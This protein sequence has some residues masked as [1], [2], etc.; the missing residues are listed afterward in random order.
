MGKD[1]PTVECKILPRNP[2]SIEMFQGHLG[3]QAIH[4]R[5]DC[6]RLCLDNRRKFAT[7]TMP[8]RFLPT[9]VL[10]ALGLFLVALTADAADQLSVWTPCIDKH[11][12]KQECLEWAW[13]GEW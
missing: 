8:I 5:S 1:G 11:E 13:Y 7:L 3:L 4:H 9:S 2:C 12:S 6:H 10:A